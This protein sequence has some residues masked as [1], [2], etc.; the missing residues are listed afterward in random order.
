MTKRGRPR[1]ERTGRDHG[2]PELARKRLEALGERREGWPEPDL[3]DAPS[4]LGVLL[5]Q[6][7]LHP[8]Y[9]T[10]K[11]MHDAGVRFAGWWMVV[12]PNTLQ[13]TLGRFVAGKGAEVDTEG[14]ER[15]LRA[16]RA[17]LGRER[18]VLD[19]VIDVTVFQRVD[20]RHLDKLRQGL[21]WLVDL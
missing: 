16:S 17:L 2:T 7:Y 8:D 9:A 12:H 13:G 4:A 14:A 5:W 20:A 21:G 19:T 6:G 3:T 1:Q 15:N 11:R 18:Q 10:A